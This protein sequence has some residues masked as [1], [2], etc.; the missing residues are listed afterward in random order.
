[1][2]EFDNC[3]TL[4]NNHIIERVDAESSNSNCV[5]RLNSKDIVLPLIVRTRCDG[6]KMLVKGMNKSKKLKDIFID[7]KISLSSR[8]TWPVVV[9][10]VGKIVWIPGIKKSIFDKNKDDIYDIILKYS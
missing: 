3:V 10:S 4:P 9:D 5:C 6:D 8:D 7:N 1:M 2:L